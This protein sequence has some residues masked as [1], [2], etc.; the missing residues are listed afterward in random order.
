ML[1]W[2]EVLQ[3]GRKLSLRATLLP[4]P[5]HG[6]SKPSQQ[7][8]ATGKYATPA[9]LEEAEALAMELRAQLQ[10][11]QFNWEAWRVGSDGE[12]CEDLINR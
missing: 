11:G 3:R 12:K 1:G 10:R 4:K 2:R 6:K 9:G 5:G 7:T 8:I